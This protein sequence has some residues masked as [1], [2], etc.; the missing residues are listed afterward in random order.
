LRNAISGGFAGGTVVVVGTFA[1]ETDQS[2]GTAVVTTVSSAIMR[3][4]SPG[5][6]A[7]IALGN[8]SVSVITSWTGRGRRGAGAVGGRERGEGGGGGDIN[9]SQ[10]GGE[11]PADQKHQNGGQT[12]VHSGDEESVGRLAKAQ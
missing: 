4:L 1:V 10:S 8:A 12:G 2:V 9:V 11:S 7:G 6:G 5:E 3:V